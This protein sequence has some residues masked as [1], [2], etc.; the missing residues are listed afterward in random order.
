MVVHSNSAEDKEQKEIPS[1]V[2]FTSLTIA[3]KFAG[4]ILKFTSLTIL[5]KLWIYSSLANG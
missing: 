1:V 2:K 4:S 3:E 5:D